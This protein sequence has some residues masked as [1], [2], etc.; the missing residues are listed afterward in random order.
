[1]NE[2][3]FLYLLQE[4]AREQERAM[5]AVPFPKIFAFIAQW[6]S[7]HPW[8]FLIPLAFIISLIFRGFL[9]SNYTDFILRLFREII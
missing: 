6:L 4:R 7:V 9:G 5:K 8:R 2:R 3:E 1:M